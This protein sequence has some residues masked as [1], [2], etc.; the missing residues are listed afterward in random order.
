MFMLTSKF[1]AV[2]WFS[3]CWH[4]GTRSRYWLR[5]FPLSC[6]SV[7]LVESFLTLFR[8]VHDSLYALTSFLYF[9][10][11]LTWDNWF[12]MTA[13]FY[14]YNFANC[15]KMISRSKPPPTWAVS[16]LTGTI[17]ACACARDPKL[18]TI[19]VVMSLFGSFWALFQQFLAEYEVTDAHLLP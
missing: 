16:W 19:N 17:N 4:M 10:T 2:I 11:N 13:F 15:W 9:P 18:I 14:Q 1:N 7:H 5:I 12:Q 6:V 8:V 3:Q